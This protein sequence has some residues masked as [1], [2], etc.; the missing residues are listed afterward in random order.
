MLVIAARSNFNSLDSGAD[1]LPFGGL[2][3][4]SKLRLEISPSSIATR[5]SIYMQLYGGQR[6][7]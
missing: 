1:N 5:H 7:T 2:V 6:E 3:R 4:S